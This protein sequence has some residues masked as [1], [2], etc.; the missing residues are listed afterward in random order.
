VDV[1]VIDG[2][3]SYHYGRSRRRLEND[4]LFGVLNLDRQFNTLI[5]D[6]GSLFLVG[7]ALLAD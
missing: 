6:I 3:R 2:G 4:Q 1:Y 5:L 7:G